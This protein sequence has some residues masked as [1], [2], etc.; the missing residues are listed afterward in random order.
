[1]SADRGPEPRFENKYIKVEEVRRVRAC[2]RE[3]VVVQHVP[4]PHVRV[5][6]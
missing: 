5:M 6:N 2:V 3:Y 1:M 4:V